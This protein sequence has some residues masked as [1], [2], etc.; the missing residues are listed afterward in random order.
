MRNRILLASL[1]LSNLL[2]VVLAAEPL[3]LRVERDVVYARFGEREVHLDWFRP[4]DEKLRPG[5][6]LIHGGG[7]VG[8]SRKAFEST[9]RDLAAAGYVVANIDYRLATEAQFPGAVLDCKAAVRWMR[10]ESE[11]LGVDPKRIA[12]IGGSAGGHL[13][14][15]VAT[16][17]GDPWFADNGNHPDR[18]DAVQA[19]I[20]MGSGV[21][22][23]A[24]VRETPGGSVKSC[25][26]FFGGEYDEVP[27]VYAKG[28][29]IT[30]L[31]KSTPPLLM[32]DGEKDR[33]GERYGE[34][35]KKLDSLGVR[36]EFRMIP[37]A[38]HGEWGKP[39]F[40]PLFVGAMTEFLAS[41]FPE[42]P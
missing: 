20:M 11:K 25:V 35:R 4:D 5:I 6:V 18:S 41:V 32:I 24:R 33:P 15:M 13:A 21:D 28:S 26:I 10:A 42:N 40:R 12:A 39:A 3:E 14:G 38:K 7:W 30:H 29:P 31:S 22:Q 8:G 37:G 19:A 9:A 16:T 1:A 27:E 36:N 23:V 2:P 34:F 17:A